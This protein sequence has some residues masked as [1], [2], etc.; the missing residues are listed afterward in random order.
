MVR[1]QN[2]DGRS[3]RS[4]WTGSPRRSK[5][6][7]DGPLNGPDHL[8]GRS[9]LTV[10]IIYLKPNLE[11]IERRIGLKILKF[12]NITKTLIFTLACLYQFSYNLWTNSPDG[13]D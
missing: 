4:N 13:P 9:G 2:L 1:P 5:D 11:N 12:L 7:L 10:L 3:G 8:D 6:I